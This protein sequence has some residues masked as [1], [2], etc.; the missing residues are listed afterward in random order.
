MVDKTPAELDAGTASDTSVVHTSENDVST[1]SRKHAER[2]ISRLQG[3]AP[4]YSSSKTYIVNDLVTESGLLFRCINSIAVPEPF[5]PANWIEVNS[6]N[7][8]ISVRNVSGSMIPKSSAVYVTGEDSGVAT[9]ELALASGVSTVPSIG[10]TQANIANNNNGNALSIG[11]L[12]NL[13]TSTFLAGDILFLSA[14]V[15]GALTTTAPTHPNLRQSLGVV[16]VSDVSVGEIEALT[17]DISGAESGTI[18]NTFAIGDGLAGTKTLSFVNAAGTF[19]ADS[20]HT[21]S[22]NQNFQDDDGII[23]L[24]SDIIDTT[25]AN[26][27]SGTGLIFRDKIGITLNLKTLLA[28]T[29][30]SVTNNADDIT[31]SLISGDAKSGS[32]TVA[33]GGTTTV[34]FNTAFSTAPNVT[35]SFATDVNYTT[36]EKGVALSVYNI[37]VNGFTVRYD[38]PDSSGIDPASF[39]WIAT[40]A[41]NP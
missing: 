9:V 39:E 2:D 16:L 13:D 29:G 30:I 24:T 32:G 31:I 35:V 38:E 22:R 14:T 19:T 28:G 33:L 12:T 15:P 21:A 37:T 20:S 36:A 25:A 3:T 11:K 26:V 17:G 34:S 10:L 23:A 18:F 1:N 27:G 4:L 40:N 6:E 5:N 8:I 41:G 7:S